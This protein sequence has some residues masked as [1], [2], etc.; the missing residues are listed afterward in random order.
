[1]AAGTDVT[2]HAV[3]AP[4]PTGA[5]APRVLMRFRGDVATLLDLP[6]ETPLAAWPLD[7]ARFVELPVGESRHTVRFIAGASEL[8][9]LKELPGGPRGASTT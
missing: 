4:D 7:A 6:W 8:L 3:A 5:M 2:P 9:A 1:M